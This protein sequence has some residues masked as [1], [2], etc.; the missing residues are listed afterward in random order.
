MK[1]MLLVI[2]IFLM[3]VSLALGFILNRSFQKKH[4]HYKIS[5]KFFGISL[6]LVTCA[7]EWFLLSFIFDGLE[8][9]L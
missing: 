1:D 8:K 6:V 9:L 2:V 3:G 4:N 7:W 5:E